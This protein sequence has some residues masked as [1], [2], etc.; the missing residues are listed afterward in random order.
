MTAGQSSF[1]LT[2]VSEDTFVF[3]PAGVEMKFDAKEGNM[4]FKQGG[5]EFVL[6]REEGN[7]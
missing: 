1:P 4:H 3:K 2:A 5:A 7:E 6:K